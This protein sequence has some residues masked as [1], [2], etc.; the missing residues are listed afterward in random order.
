MQWLLGAKVNNYK[1]VL[2]TTPEQVKW[3]PDLE[4]SFED[5]DE[6]SR[7][8]CSQVYLCFHLFCN[9]EEKGSLGRERCECRERCVQIGKRRWRR[10]FGWA[11]YLGRVADSHVVL[12]AKYLGGLVYDE[13]LVQLLASCF[14]SLGSWM[15]LP[16]AHVGL[17]LAAE[18][19]G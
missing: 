8:K 1:N 10:P 19:L 16:S 3:S 4:A 6:K 7:D 2:S 15:L 11:Q 9:G 13:P 17:D 14:W 5:E 12:W 18:S